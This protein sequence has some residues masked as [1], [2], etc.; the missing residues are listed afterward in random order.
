MVQN[1]RVSGEGGVYERRPDAPAR[2]TPE[3]RAHRDEQSLAD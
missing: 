2:G 3:L 1:V